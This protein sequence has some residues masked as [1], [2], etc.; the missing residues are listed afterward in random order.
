M[1]GFAKRAYAKERR[2]TMSPQSKNEGVYRGI[3]HPSAGEIRTFCAKRPVGRGNER[4]AERAAEAMPES[5][6]AESRG[7]DESEFDG[8]SQNLRQM[9]KRPDGM[10]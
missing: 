8:R 1:V 4:E 6:G 7:E 10:N 2:Q 9:W 3:R 5:L